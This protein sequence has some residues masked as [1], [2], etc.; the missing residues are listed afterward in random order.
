MKERI[1]LFKNVDASSP[2]FGHLAQPF[3]RDQVQ[4]SPI[5][6]LCGMYTDL[7]LSQGSPLQHPQS[8]LG[9]Q[10]LHRAPHYLT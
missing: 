4:A 3:L 1:T 5:H 7:V 6:S 9:M 8:N 10:H 2:F